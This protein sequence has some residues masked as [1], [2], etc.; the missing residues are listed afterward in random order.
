[1]SWRNGEERRKREEGEGGRADVRAESQTDR[2]T[3]TDFFLLI[4]LSALKRHHCARRFIFY[5]YLSWKKEGTHHPSLPCPSSPFSVHIVPWRISGLDTRSR[6]RGGH[7]KRNRILSHLMGAGV[8]RFRPFLAPQQCRKRA[9]HSQGSILF[10]RRRVQRRTI[11]QKIHGSKRRLQM[12]NEAERKGGESF[13]TSG[14]RK[15]QLD[16]GAEFRGLHLPIFSLL[17]LPFLA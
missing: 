15:T 9:G 12:A 3:D 4:F 8:T 7:S 2:Q 5:S 13:L 14:Q 1:M 6:W 11:H 16:D 10:R 17:S